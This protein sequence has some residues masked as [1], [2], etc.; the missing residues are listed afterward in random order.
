MSPMRTWMLVG[1]TSSTFALAALSIAA[2]VYGEGV[3]ITTWTLLLALLCLGLWV[4]YIGAVVR[5]SIADLIERRAEQ[6]KQHIDQ[7]F[8]ERIKELEAGIEE[9][10]DAKENEGQMAAYRN[11]ARTGRQLRLAP[12]D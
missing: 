1:S 4:G 10:G 7:H 9:F 2:H 5:D 12:V 3:T 6:L 11:I 8:D